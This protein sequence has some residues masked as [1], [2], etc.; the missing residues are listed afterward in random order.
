MTRLALE[1]SPPSS[2]PLRFLLAAPWWGMAAGVL[3]LFDA[4][5]LLQSRWHPATLA[6][7]HAFTLG[8]IGNLIFGSLLQ[9]L[10]A[11]AGVRLHGAACG[12]PLCLLFNIGVFLLTAGLYL[13]Q[14]VLLACAGGALALG[15]IL[16]AGMTGP[17]LLTA[18]GQLLLRAGLGAAL[19]AA[20]VTA[21]GGVVLAFALSGRLATSWPL[22]LLTDAHAAW[23]VA[24]WVLLTLGSVSRVV[25]PMFLGTTAT[26]PVAQMAWTVATLLL[27]AAASVMLLTG[28]SAAPLRLVVTGT[29]LAF[30]GAALMQLRAVPPRNA[31]LRAWWRSGLLALSAFALVLPWQLRSDLL[32]GVLGVAVALPLL[33]IGMQLEIVAFLGWIDLHRRCGRGTRL[34][35]VHRLLPDADKW[36]VLFC[37]LATAPLQLAAVVKPSV[38]LARAAGLGLLLSYALLWHVL[39]GVRRRATRFLVQAI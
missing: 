31:P 35:S 34:P 19:L 38:E 5:E 26:P 17:G 12:G 10:P 39:S 25:M 9:F 11:A 22:P 8:V 37:F 29:T 15:F 30:A 32:T 33:T 2:T 28:R 18:C 20:L 21:A 27:L 7:T 3:L 4:T 36:R 23:G 13:S 16:F 24:G 14:P 6:A 1:R